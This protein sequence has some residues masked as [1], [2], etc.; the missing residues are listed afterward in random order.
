MH[1]DGAPDEAELNEIYG[2]GSWRIGEAQL[3]RLC[4]LLSRVA[5]NMMDEEVYIGGVRANISRSIAFKDGTMQRAEHRPH[6]VHT[7]AFSG[8]SS[9]RMVRSS[10]DRLRH[11]DSNMDGRKNQK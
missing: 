1:K 7:Q 3:D 2:G 6:L 9:T 4:E 11:V 8:Q 10:R 5:R